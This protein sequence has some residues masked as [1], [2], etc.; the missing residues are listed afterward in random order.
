MIWNPTQA[1]I[2]STNVWRFMRRL[3]F[4][5]REAFLRFSREESRALLGRDDARNGRR[6]VRALP[7]GARFAAAARSGRSGSP[8]AASTSRTTAWTAGRKPIASPA[9][10][11]PRTA[12][13][14]ASHSRESAKKPDRVANG[15]RALGLEAGDRVALCMPMVPEILADPLRL[16]QG[17]ADRR[18]DIRRLRRGRDRHAPGGFRRAGAV[19]RRLIWSGAAN[20]IPLASKMPPFTGEHTIVLRTASWDDFLR[21]QSARIAD[22][23][24]RFRGPRL[25]PLHLR[26]HRQAKGHRPHARR[27]P[28]A[29][30]QGDLAGVRP[31]AEDDRF[32]WLSR[33]RL[34]DG[35]VDHP[36]QSPVRRHDLPV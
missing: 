8:A 16:F 21:R 11:K 20:V 30:G 35:A 9:S 19:H 2:E 7:A 24:A 18:P 33:H 23:L 10:G 29:N 14:A 25:H 17:G 32:F 1:W 3:G 36:R 12:P 27:L 22:P 31:P 26:H 6:V 5:D 15:L 13:P 4:S 28:G 34:D